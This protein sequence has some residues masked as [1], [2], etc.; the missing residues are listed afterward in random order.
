MR[1]PGQGLDGYELIWAARV[2]VDLIELLWEVGR[3]VFGFI[4][5][6]LRRLRSPEGL[7]LHHAEICEVEQTIVLASVSE[8]RPN[9]DALIS[10]CTDDHLVIV[11]AHVGNSFGVA[12]E[13]LIA[14]RAF[15]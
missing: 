5:Q 12:D 4:F 7:G 6:L 15:D 9:E 10:T 8:E 1:L 13:G 11:H 14:S 2:D 3:N